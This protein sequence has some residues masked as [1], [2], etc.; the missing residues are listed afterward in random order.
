MEGA[1]NVER[2]GHRATPL[3]RRVLDCDNSHSGIGATADHP[4]R[5]RSAKESTCLRSLAAEID[6]LLLLDRG[7]TPVRLARRTPAA[8]D[9]LGG[10]GVE[11]KKK[12]TTR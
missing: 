9:L 6:Q 11:N 2:G 8:A 5:H 7:D 10:P 12:S 4:V 1:T 3:L